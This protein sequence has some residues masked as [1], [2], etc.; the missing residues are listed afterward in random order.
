[1]DRPYVANADQVSCW[2]ALA[3]Q[4]WVHQRE[5]MDIL[6]GP[7]SDVLFSQAEIA[8]GMSVIDIGCG[9]GD[10]S[11]RAGRQ[12]GPDGHVL[13]LDISRPML[14]QA[15]SRRPAE[16]PVTFTEGDATTYPFTPTADLWFSRFGVMFFAEPLVSFVNMRKALRP[17]GRVAFVCWREMHLCSWLTVPYDAAL[18]HVPR[19]DDAPP[20]APGAFALADERYVR[21]ILKNAGYID[22]VMQ[23]SDLLL[24]LAAGRGLAAAINCVLQIGPTSRLLI[25]QPAQVRADAVGS[26]SESLKRFKVGESIL[27]GGAIWMVTAMNP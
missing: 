2:N 26:I 18:R 1:M 13:G 7:V 10:T 12:V 17:R 22:V 5:H 27:L 16:L 23:P 11:L 19:P 20:N 9:C 24:D 14:D 15:R 6:L 25:D 21:S 4:Q 8:P 3:G